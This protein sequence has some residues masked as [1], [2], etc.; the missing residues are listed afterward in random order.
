MPRYRPSRRPGVAVLL[1]LALL[2]VWRI[3]PGLLRDAPPEQLL[4]GRHRVERIVDADTLIVDGR[5][6]RLI[7][8]NAPET[9]RPDYPV[10]PW[11]PEASQFTRDFLADGDIRLTFDRERVDK[12]DRL[13]AYVWV[14]DRMLNEELVRAGLARV[15]FN[16]RYSDSVKR[17][18]RKA[19]EEAK[20]ARRGIW[21][22]W[23]E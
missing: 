21:S 15:E 3:A 18:Y 7:G 4:E 16:H 1:V 20:A 13:L 6:V 23:D 8:V 5:R 10:E 14:G 19:L 17:R 12:Y 22:D 2:L 9:V 11:G